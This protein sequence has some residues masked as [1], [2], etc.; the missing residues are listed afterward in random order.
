M[1]AVADAS[2]VCYLVLIGQVELLPKLFGRI[3]LP[4]AVLSELRHPHAP[5]EVQAWARA[6]PEWVSVM[7]SPHSVD[8]SLEK[9]HA[10]ERAC[11]LLAESVRADLLLLDEKSARH[12]AVAR[13]LRVTGLLGILGEAAS[14]D[15]TS[16]LPAIEGLRKT[17]FR[18]SPALLREA[19]DRF[20]PGK[21]P[22]E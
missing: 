8:R 10:G 16:F 12:A 2:P 13:G 11:I 20:G 7:D 21:K 3:L 1:T 5:G 9:L 22:L 6:L 14:R 18:I 15:L 19:L 17:S 4:T